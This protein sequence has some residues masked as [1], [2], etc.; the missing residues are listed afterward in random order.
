[1]VFN[2]TVALLHSKNIKFQICCSVRCLTEHF[3]QNL[4]EKE[5]CEL[6]RSGQV[7]ITSK[8]LQQAFEIHYKLLNDN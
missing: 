2:A 1:M 8:W 3:I 5:Y 7:A 6:F 4:Q